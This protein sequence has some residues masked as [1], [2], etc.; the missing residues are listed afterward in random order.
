MKAEQTLK[1]QGQWTSFVTRKVRE[2]RRELIVELGSEPAGRKRFCLDSF[3]QKYGVYYC[4]MR[5]VKRRSIF[6]EDGALIGMLDKNFL[7]WQHS[8]S[9]DLALLFGDSPVKENFGDMIQNANV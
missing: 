8:M 9:R 5:E 6:A 1:K 3:L 4:M 7:A 2:M